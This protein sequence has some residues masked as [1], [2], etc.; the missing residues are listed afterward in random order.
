MTIQ[1][2][3]CDGQWLLYEN[4]SMSC[5]GNLQTFT[6]QE[7]RDQLAPSIPPAQKA[8]LTGSII[9]L[10]ALVWVGRQLMNIPR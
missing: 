3:G 2:L 9:G 1:F 8:I 10:L 4:G 5:Q 7:M 6:V